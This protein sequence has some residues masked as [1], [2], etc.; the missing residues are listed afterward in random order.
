MALAIC[1]IFWIIWSLVPAVAEK[2]LCLTLCLVL[3]IVCCWLAYVQLLLPSVF[4]L[5][6][7]DVSVYLAAVT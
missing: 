7:D 1:S 4:S 3:F 5:N 6:H 2:D